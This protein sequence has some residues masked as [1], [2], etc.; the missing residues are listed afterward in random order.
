MSSKVPEEVAPLK[1]VSEPCCASVR[2]DSDFDALV[3]L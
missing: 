1:R 3:I 2:L